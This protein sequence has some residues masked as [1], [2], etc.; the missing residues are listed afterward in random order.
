MTGA[1]GRATGCTL[2][3]KTI[4]IALSKAVLLGHLEN[5]ATWCT[6]LVRIHN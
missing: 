4:E 6:L 5:G 1:I 2:Y 3:A